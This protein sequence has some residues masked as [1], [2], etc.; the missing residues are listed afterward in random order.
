MVTIIFIFIF[1][2]FFLFVFLSEKV[3]WDVL[4][5]AAA[6]NLTPAGTQRK[7]LAENMLRTQVK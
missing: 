2:C 5:H 6:R 4:K 1:H 7:M 3:A